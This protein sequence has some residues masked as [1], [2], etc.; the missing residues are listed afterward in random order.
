LPLKDHAIT[1]K[2]PIFTA[3]VYNQ[4]PI[5]FTHDDP[6]ENPSLAAAS[7]SFLQWLFAAGS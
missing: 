3:A 2:K 4:L 5:K 6:I 1:G 7:H